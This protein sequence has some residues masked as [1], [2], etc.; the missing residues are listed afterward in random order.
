MPGRLVEAVVGPT[1]SQPLMYDK[2]VLFSLGLKLKIK[3]KLCRGPTY[4]V[5]KNLKKK[6][7]R[8]KKPNQFTAHDLIWGKIITS[9]YENFQK[10]ADFCFLD[11]ESTSILAKSRAELFWDLFRLEPVH[12]FS[13]FCLHV[14]PCGLH[15]NS[16]LLL[17]YKL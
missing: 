11:M 10:T 1:S 4:M 16:I 2:S 8:K 13:D 6:N 7:T 12:F 14:L 5:P 9:F 17:N 15:Q 3:K